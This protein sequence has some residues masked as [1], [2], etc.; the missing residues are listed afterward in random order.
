MSEDLLDR[1]ER[2]LTIYE[3]TKRMELERAEIAAKVASDILASNRKAQLELMS[4]FNQ[5]VTCTTKVNHP[6]D[7]NQ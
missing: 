1:L 3:R 6:Q 4:Y 7:E 5:F 2:L